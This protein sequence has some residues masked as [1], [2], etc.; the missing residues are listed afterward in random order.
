MTWK[1]LKEKIDKMTPEQQEQ[2]VKC[3]G[4]E[5]PLMPASLHACK[6]DMYWGKYYE[7]CVPESELDEDEKNDPYA[8]VYA[9][10]GTMYLWCE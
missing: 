2:A 3:W 8:F 1:E 4:E 7:F 10:K 6:E 5:R 9:K